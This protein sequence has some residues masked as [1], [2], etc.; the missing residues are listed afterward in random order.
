MFILILIV[1]IARRVKTTEEEIFLANYGTLFEEFEFNGLSSCYFYLIFVIRRYSTI[2]AVLF[3]SSPLFKIL[4]SF[5]FSLIVIVTQTSLYLLFVNP[6]K[7]KINQVYLILNEALTAVFYGYLVLQLLEIIYYD[8]TTQG[9]ICIK[10]IEVALGL[11]CV[12]GLISGFWNAYQFF[13]N[14]RKRKIV[15]FNN[16]NTQSTINYYENSNKNLDT[17]L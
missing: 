8:S 1:L 16:F 14:C 7:D 5:L 2:A 15:P 12:F 4:I 13:K 6:C 17:N 9:E 10:V 3:F 11:N